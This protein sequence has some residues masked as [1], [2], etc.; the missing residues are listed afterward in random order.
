MYIK[1]LEK[2]S[3]NIPYLF[4]YLHYFVI[5]SILFF[6]ACKLQ[7]SY[8]PLKHES[9]TSENY[10]KYIDRMRKAYDNK[11]YY[12]VALQ[13]ANLK[14]PKEVVLK[15]LKK[16]ITENQTACES[17]YNVQRFANEGFYQNIYKHDTVAFKTAFQICLSKLGEN[18]FDFYMEKQERK[19]EEYQNTLPKIDSTLIDKQLIIALEEIKKDDQKYRKKI[20]DF[21]TKEENNHYWRL[22]DELDSINLI[23]VDSILKIKGYPKPKVVGYDLSQTVF[24]VLHH[25][26]NIEIRKKYRPLIEQISKGSD[27]I[28]VYDERTNRLK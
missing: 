22:Q 4:V 20:N 23:K 18:S 19:T 11:N 15:Y 24:V 27:L 10:E 21:N 2:K 13:L 8:V 9:L 26:T 25:Q 3:K 7:K 17:I 1:T 5:I 16:S 28:D 14:A 12:N 6:S